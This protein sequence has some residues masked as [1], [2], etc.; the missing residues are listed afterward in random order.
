[1]SHLDLRFLRG[2][3]G[4]EAGSQ[5]MEPAAEHLVA[6]E[7]CRTLAGTVLDEIRAEDPQFQVAD[8]LQVV[9]ALIDRERQWGVESLAAVAEWA[10]LR[11][12]PR[13]SQRD[14]VRMSKVCQTKA[15]FGLVLGEL[16]EEP[17]WREAEFL[18]GLA[19]LCVQGMSRQGQIAVAAGHDLQAEAWIAV[20]N[21]RRRAAEWV[22]AHQALANA[23]R[24]LEKGTKQPQRRAEFLS[25]TASTLA[26]EGQVFEALEAL[27]E[28]QE[29]YQNHSEWTLLAHTLVKLANVLVEKKPVQALAALD[30]ALPLIP[31]EDCYLTLLAEMLR[32]ECLIVVHKPNEA[33]RVFRRCSRLLTL[34]SQIRVRIRTK[35]TGARLLDA[36]GFKR[37]AERLFDEVVD[38]DIEH[39]LYKDAALDL[40]YLYQHHVKAGDLEKA[41][42]AYRRALTELSVSEVAHQQ[43]CDLW[44]P[45]LDAAHYPAID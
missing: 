8:P 33:L 32:V 36:L 34:N 39:E 24:H 37:Q 3:L 43:I 7:S 12:L 10:E 38:R 25:I 17:C 28:C 11:R 42:R 20:A 44:A 31:Q 29:I 35:F 15:F 6:C 4:G 26:D 41:A 21:S 5:E 40:L 16:K 2:L 9:A 14:R 23:Q 27:Y 18:A 1:M 45:L 19:L 30:R 22:R 13:R